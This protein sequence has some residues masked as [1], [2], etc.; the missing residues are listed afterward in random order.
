MSIFRAVD[1]AGKN[2]PLLPQP[3]PQDLLAFQYGVERREDPGNEIVTSATIRGERVD[4]FTSNWLPASIM[5][6]DL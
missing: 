4:Y 1:N 6:N 5:Q 2:P 3:R